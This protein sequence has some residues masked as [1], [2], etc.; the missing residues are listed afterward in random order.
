MQELQ[1]ISDAIV[2]IIREDNQSLIDFQ[3]D[4][5]RKMESQI[6]RKEACMKLDKMNLKLQQITGANGRITPGLRKQNLE[7]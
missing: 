1:L 6:L 5:F 3:E 7:H 4:I 2:P